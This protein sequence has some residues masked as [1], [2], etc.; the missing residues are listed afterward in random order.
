M[1]QRFTERTRRIIF[2]AQ[3]EASR[4]GKNEVGSEHLLLGLIRE[5]DSAGGRILT[6]LGADVASLR[7]D[8]ATKADPNVVAKEMQLT[9]DAKRVIDLAYEAARRLSHNYIG[10]EHLLLGMTGEDA[11]A[12]GRALAKQGVDYDKVYAEVLKIRQ[13]EGERR[14]I[15]ILNLQTSSGPV[16]IP[17]DAVRSVTV[18]GAFGTFEGT[19]ESIT[20]RNAAE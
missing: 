3:E 13:N 11:G 19:I 18:T 15:R 14:T 2:F 5:M 6:S 10:T 9:Q 20:E 4:C 8:L 16:S 17:L 7:R 12:A 1:W